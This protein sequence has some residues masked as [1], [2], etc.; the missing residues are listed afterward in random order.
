MLSWIQTLLILCPQ[1]RSHIAS[2]HRTAKKKKKKRKSV[3]LWLRAWMVGAD[4]FP[5]F[6]RKY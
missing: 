5:K 1:I 4:P 2:E 6:P 3:I